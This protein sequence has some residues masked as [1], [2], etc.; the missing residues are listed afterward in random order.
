M[1]TE[2]QTTVLFPVWRLVKNKFKRFTLLYIG[3]LSTS[4]SERV[5]GEQV[6]LPFLLLCCGIKSMYE[7][8]PGPGFLHISTSLIPPVLKDDVERP[9]FKASWYGKPRQGIWFAPGLLWVRRMDRDTSWNVNASSGDKGNFPYT[10]EVFEK[11]YADT[12]P[13]ATSAPT[14][15][16]LTAFDF[17]RTRM[18]NGREWPVPDD[19]NKENTPRRR[20]YIYDLPI[21]DKLSTAIGSPDP[22][23]ILHIN[24]ANL[25]AFEQA[26][27]AFYKTVREGTNLTQDIQIRINS[28]L[29]YTLEDKRIPNKL[30]TTRTAVLTLLRKCGVGQAILDTLYNSFWQNEATGSDILRFIDMKF[31]PQDKK[32]AERSAWVKTTK[33]PAYSKIAKGTK[34]MVPEEAPAEMKMYLEGLYRRPKEDEQEMVGDLDWIL[35]SEYGK[36]IN[37]VLM[38]QWGGLYF[39]PDIFPQGDEPW[40]FPDRK[41][42]GALYTKYGRNLI[43]F[44]FFMWY[45]VASGCVWSPTKVFGNGATIR[46]SF[47]IM[48]S[49]A[50]VTGVDDAQLFV[51][52]I[53]KAK[54]EDP[55]QDDAVFFYKT[56]AI[57]PSIVPATGGRR[58]LKT[59]RRSRK[60]KKGT[61]K[62]R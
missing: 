40:V 50:E 38:K 10:L 11:I 20:Y 3:S 54:H 35:C 4:H 52:G 18:I 23:K 21:S 60:L 56:G 62:I 14:S 30:A 1:K 5:T 27:F 25:D 13:V 24:A 45:D 41:D 2:K 49:D 53:D 57:Q 51:G 15:L 19:L 55:S 61:R 12:P 9:F 29:N 43:R 33:F 16:P 58:H 28:Y 26:F 31:P 6:W 34:Y 22:T 8:M 47:S 48:F 17:G 46:P 36:F 39:D 42:F 32:T 7:I 59:F 37:E 44:P